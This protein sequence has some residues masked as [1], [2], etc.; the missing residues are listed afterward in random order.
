MIAP[1]YAK[2]L[3]HA[4]SVLGPGPAYDA[5]WPTG[6]LRS[7]WNLALQRVYQE[8][9]SLPVVPSAQAV[10]GSKG[11]GW[12]QPNQVTYLDDAVSK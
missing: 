6:T 4:A 5:L 9:A 3:Q 7:P 8:V 1:L 11:S 12:M 2:V 10:S